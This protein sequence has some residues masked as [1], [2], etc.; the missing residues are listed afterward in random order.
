MVL[1]PQRQCITD[2]IVPGI[3]V[4]TDEEG[5]KE[6]GFRVRLLLDSRGVDLPRAYNP[7][8][9]ILS[10]LKPLFFNGLKNEPPSWTTQE[11]KTLESNKS[12]KRIQEKK[13][14]K[15]LC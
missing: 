8:C 7:T 13:E 5:F 12:V 1:G 10:F 3:R 9:I 6:G 2:T 11:Q 4:Y 14:W 15:R